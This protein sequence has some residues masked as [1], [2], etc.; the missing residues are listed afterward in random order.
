M[1]S[2]PAWL[3]PAPCCASLAGDGTGGES[4]WGGEFEDEFHKALR[5][6]R[7]G[8]L[9][10]WVGGRE[11]QGGSEG[12]AGGRW[13]WRRRVAGVTGGTEAGGRQAG[14]R[15]GAHVSCSVGVA[16]GDVQ[17]CSGRRLLRA[18]P[19]APSCP[20]PALAG[21]MRVQAQTEASELPSGCGAGRHTRA[22]KGASAQH[23]WPAACLLGVH[24][25]QGAPIP[26]L[27]RLVLCAGS[28]S[29]R[30]RR[31]GWTTSTP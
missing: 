14:G 18:C 13:S 26:S 4:I 15:A 30:C 16:Y 19:Q 6:D 7:P 5:H 22:R 8:I 20:P 11:G 27:P 1:R 29:P 17:S 2:E 10:M 24:S 23:S 31:P 21:R 9:S 28:S 25:R 12:V 3:R